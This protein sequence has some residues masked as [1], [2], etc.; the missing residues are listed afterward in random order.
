MGWGVVVSSLRR[1]SKTRDNLPL[2]SIEEPRQSLQVLVPPEPAIVP[3]RCQAT[4][5]VIARISAYCDI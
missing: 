5:P 3:S 1:L 2:I 4:V